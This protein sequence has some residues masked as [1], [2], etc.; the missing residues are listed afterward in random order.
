MEELWN[1]IL[2]IWF[3]NG[4]EDSNI[5]LIKANTKSAYYWDNEG[6]KIVNFIKM[7]GSLITEND[8][9]DAKKGK[10]KI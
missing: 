2:K 8:Y 5:S 4:G 7:I 9:V 6:G 10:I 3:K 1:P